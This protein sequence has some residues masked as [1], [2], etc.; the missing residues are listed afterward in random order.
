M[1]MR[2]GEKKKSHRYGWRCLPEK[3][4]S[5]LPVKISSS[6][7][8]TATINSLP[9]TW[10]CKRCW[11]PGLPK[12]LFSIPLISLPGLGLVEKMMDI[13][14]V[15]VALIV[16]DFAHEWREAGLN[17][18]IFN[19]RGYPELFEAY[20]SALRSSETNHRQVSRNSTSKS[21]LDI[22]PSST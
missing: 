20:L 18:V 15:L 2:G 21:S 5:S 8:E 19:L 16:I 1:F 3:D 9:Q 7:L 12:A 11:R 14:V 10:P 22:K 6:R 13:L 17:V 4:A